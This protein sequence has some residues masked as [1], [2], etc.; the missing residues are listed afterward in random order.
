MFSGGA[1]HRHSREFCDFINLPANSN[2]PGTII[3]MR[4]PVE[5]EEGFDYSNYIQ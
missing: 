5:V 3:L 2:W 4:I 1:F